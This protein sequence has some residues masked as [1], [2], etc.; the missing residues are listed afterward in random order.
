ELLDLVAAGGDVTLRFKEVEDVDLSF[1]QILCSA[2]RSLVNNG[3]TMVIDGQLPESMM[4]LIDEAG[5]KVHI[6]CTFDS[7]VECPWLQKN[8]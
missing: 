5:L 4:K 3:K 6:G 1:I 2:H 7:T 8:I